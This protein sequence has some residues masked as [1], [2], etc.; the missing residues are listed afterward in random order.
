[1]EELRCPICG[2]PVVKTEEGIYVCLNGHVVEEE[3]V[4]TGPEWRSFT[5]EEYVARR[6]VGSPLT[7]R[8]H[9]LGVSTAISRSR[10]PRYQRLAALHR[11]LRVEGHQK[12]VEALQALNRAVALL[13][14]PNHIAET[15]AA[16]L[17]KLEDS[18]YRLGAGQRL[19]ENIAALIVAAS[20][21][22]GRSPL[23]LREAA[24]RLA[25]NE[26]RVAKA[27]REIV[28][29]LGVRPRP[30]DPTTYLPRLSQQLRLSPRIETLAARLLHALRSTGAAQGKP[31]LGLAAAA[32][33]LASILL[34]EKKSQTEIAKAAGVTD[35]TIRNR[36]RDIVDNLYIEVRL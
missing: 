4:D 12:L 8:L 3:A 28:S 35:M 18:D 22:D 17:K 19:M 9:D 23:P 26:K 16:L 29:R 1:M 36:Y 32:V 31:P 5:S 10:D 6:R 33:Y 30:L 24:K 7:Q 11:R 21:I 2:A 14:L 13:G 25:L 20:R 34:D 15:A 27:Y